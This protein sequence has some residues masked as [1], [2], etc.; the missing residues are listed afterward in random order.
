MGHVDVGA[1]V[2]IIA[3]IIG[4]P[5]HAG[6]LLGIWTSEVNLWV[7]E[8]FLMLKGREFGHVLLHS[9]LRGLQGDGTALTTLGA[10]QLPVGHWETRPC[11][12]V[13]VFL[14]Q[15]LNMY[16]L[17]V[18]NVQVVIHCVLISPNLKEKTITAIRAQGYQWGQDSV[19][20]GPRTQN[21]LRHHTANE[22]SQNTPQD[23]SR[24]GDPDS[25][26]I[27]QSTPKYTRHTYANMACKVKIY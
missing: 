20:P 19:P 26:E 9:L 21:A 4:A 16:L 5:N 2:V 14:K 7:V 13:A 24:H 23:R 8:Y 15:L 10:L 1:L 3:T 22:T 11:P 17:V 6:P 18:P 27:R 25:A 12:F